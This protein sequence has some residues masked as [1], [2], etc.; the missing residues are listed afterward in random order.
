MKLPLA[1][2]AD[3]YEYVDVNKKFEAILCIS[4]PQVG[5]VEEGKTEKRVTFHVSKLLPFNVQ[6]PTARSNLRL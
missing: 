6:T 5:S 1:G 3:I 4:G 2:Y